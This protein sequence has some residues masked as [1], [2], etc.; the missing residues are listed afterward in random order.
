MM[1]FSVSPNPS[2]P[3]NTP[4]LYEAGEELAFTGAQTTVLIVIGCVILFVGLLMVVLG[5]HRD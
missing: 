3:D 2:V 4:G 5:G 1:W